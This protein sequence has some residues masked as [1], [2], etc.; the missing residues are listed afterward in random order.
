MKEREWKRGQMRV[1]HLSVTV[2]SSL[3]PPVPSFPCP[4]FIS[5]QLTSVD[6]HFCT[7]TYLQ[8]GFHTFIHADKWR[9]LLLKSEETT[10]LIDVRMC[11]QIYFFLVYVICFF[12]NI[13]EAELLVKTKITVIKTG[14]KI[15]R[16]KNKIAMWLSVL[17]KSQRL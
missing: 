11:T 9:P 13:R 12:K 10:S 14:C 17:N 3:R 1:A 8:T 2:R 16:K 7:F 6:S 15:N 5:F 4:P